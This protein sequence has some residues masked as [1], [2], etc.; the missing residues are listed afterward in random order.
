MRLFLVGKVAEAVQALD[1]EK[2]KRSVDAAR[3]KKAEA[4]KSLAVAIEGYLL[5][6]RLL[7]VQF[8]FRRLR[9]PT[10]QL[11]RRTQ[12]VR[13]LRLCGV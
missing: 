8:R 7:T 12:A 2:L 11:L 1:A 5:K 3:R 9:R 6:A 4:E 13:Q 10:R